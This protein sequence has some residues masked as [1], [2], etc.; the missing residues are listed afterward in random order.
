[1]EAELAG[2]GDAG[3]G[4]E[5]EAAWD[6]RCSARAGAN[7]PIHCMTGCGPPLEVHLF[8]RHVMGNL[9]G[10]RLGIHIRKPTNSEYI[11]L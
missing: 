2:E 4:R 1:M 8:L 10:V 5:V 3:G 7:Y 9:A 6:G 11:K